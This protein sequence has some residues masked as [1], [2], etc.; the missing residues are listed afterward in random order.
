MR[1]SP[2]TQFHVI[3]DF[4]YHQGIHPN[5][6]MIWSI[7]NFSIRMD[8]QLHTFPHP[9]QSH[10]HNPRILMWKFVITVASVTMQKNCLLLKVLM[11]TYVIC[12]GGCLILKEPQRKLLCDI[13]L[14]VCVCVCVCVCVNRTPGCAAWTKYQVLEFQPRSGITIVLGS[15]YY[16][17]VPII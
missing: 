16:L 3:F 6:P 14:F 4:Y 9:K 7:H 2:E 13:G 8:K 10:T 11:F 15:I 17:Y 1:G 12:F 5:H